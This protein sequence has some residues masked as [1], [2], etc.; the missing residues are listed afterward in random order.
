[1]YIGDLLPTEAAVSLCRGAD[2]LICEATFCEDMAQRAVET[3]HS[4][5]SRTCWLARE[6]GAR[7]LVLTHFSPRYDEEAISGEVDFPRTLVA[8]DGLTLEVRYP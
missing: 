4:T 1:V 3:G 6:S 7:R 2:V 5:V 8:K